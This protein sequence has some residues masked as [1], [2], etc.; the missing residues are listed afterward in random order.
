MVNIKNFMTKHSFIPFLYESC[1][2]I[3]EKYDTNFYN[4]VIFLEKFGEIE[5]YSKWNIVEVRIDGESAPHIYCRQYEKE[6]D[7]MCIIM[8]F[9]II[10]VQPLQSEL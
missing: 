7:G 9:K 6:E 8:T 10:E 2:N 4:N 3:T 5:K 1:N